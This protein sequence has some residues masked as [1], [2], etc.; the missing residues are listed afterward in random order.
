MKSFR[1]EAEGASRTY[2]DF[3]LGFGLC[4]TVYLAL[5]G[6]LL[7]QLAGIARDHPDG[8]RPMIASFFL[9]SVALAILSWR[10]IFAVPAISF[11]GIAAI[12]GVAFFA[13]RNR[14]DGRWG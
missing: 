12:L 2:F 7:W 8:V 14:Q 13:R 1:F 6:V 10:L 9:A 11:A 3:Y 4:L 5:Q